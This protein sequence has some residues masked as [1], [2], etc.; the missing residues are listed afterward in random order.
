MRSS[1]REQRFKRSGSPE[2]NA[3]YTAFQQ[4]L[5]EDEALD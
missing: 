5:L 1:D 2:D 3:L 4:L